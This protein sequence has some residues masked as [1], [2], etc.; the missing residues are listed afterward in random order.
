MSQ[1]L[2]YLLA[3]YGLCFALQYK[4]PFLRG[5][6][7]FTDALLSCSFCTGFHCGWIAWL[8]RLAIMGIPASASVLALAVSAASWAFAS[9]AFCYVTDLA[10]TWIESQVAP[11]GE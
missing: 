10:T 9:A 11:G 4:A 7:T 1:I 2:P 5:R 3:A 6:T 8:A